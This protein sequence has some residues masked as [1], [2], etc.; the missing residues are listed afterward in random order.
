MKKKEKGSLLVIVSKS[1][2]KQIVKKI[3][4]LYLLREL[5]ND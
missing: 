1:I 3:Y 5:H 2:E 4:L